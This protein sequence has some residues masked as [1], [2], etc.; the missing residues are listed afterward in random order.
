MLNSEGNEVFLI[1]MNGGPHPGT[2]WISEG[3]ES[4]GFDPKWPLPETFIDEDGHYVKTNEN[5][6]PALLDAANVVRG[7]EY[8]W[9]QSE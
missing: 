6:L 3:D 7:A 2:R 4:Y 1:R 8:E 9:R 5:Q